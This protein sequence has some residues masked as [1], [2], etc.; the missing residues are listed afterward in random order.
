MSVEIYLNFP[1]VAGAVNNRDHKGWIEMLTCD[2]GLARGRPRATAA[3]KRPS[4]IT[5]GNEITTTKNI[6]VESA[7]LMD[8]CTSGAISEQAQISVVPTVA[9]REVQ[10]KYLLITLESVF[11]K[12]IKTSGLSTE[13]FFTEELV[14]GFR[15]FR[16]EYFIPASRNLSAPV[17]EIESRTFEFD[18][19]AQSSAT[20]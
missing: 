18:F 11:I 3:G 10:H 2:W 19:A 16:F 4:A 1:D 5:T 12:S 20:E 17:A 9:K 7:A 8:L 13:N 6:G 15:K 14:F